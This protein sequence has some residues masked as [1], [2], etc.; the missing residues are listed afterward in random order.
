[1]EFVD[2][3]VWRMLLTLTIELVEQPD[4]EDRLLTVQLYWKG[5]KK[6]VSTMFIGSSPEFELALYTLYFLVGEE[7]NLVEILDYEVKIR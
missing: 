1:M 5:E 7:D 4:G 6:P 2:S 3:T